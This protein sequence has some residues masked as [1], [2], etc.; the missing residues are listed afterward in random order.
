MSASECI[1][2][3]STANKSANAKFCL[4][5]KRKEREDEEESEMKTRKKRVERRLSGE[6]SKEMV[7][8]REGEKKKKKEMRDEEE[9]FSFT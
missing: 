2:T 8:W 9:C 6:E 7:K 4:F 3:E 5:E 1:C